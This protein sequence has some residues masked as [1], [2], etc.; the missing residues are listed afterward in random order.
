MFL[1]SLMVYMWSGVCAWL[2][3]LLSC[4]IVFTWKQS[5]LHLGLLRGTFSDAPAVNGDLVSHGDLASSGDFGGQSS[6]SDPYLDRNV[7]LFPR[8]FSSERAGTMS[9]FFPKSPST[10]WFMFWCCI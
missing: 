8:Y 6:S 9:T 1:I 5:S 4:L 3:V 7:A 2:V 10:S